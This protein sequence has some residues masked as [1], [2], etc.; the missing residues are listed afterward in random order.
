MPDYVEDQYRSVETIFDPLTTPNTRLQGPLV[1]TIFDGPT[2]RIFY[3]AQW[4]GIAPGWFVF[5][6]N[7]EY[8]GRLVKMVARPDVPPR[9]YKHWNGQLSRGWWKKCDAQE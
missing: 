3:V 2:T 7:E 1:E 8:G 5:G 9:K 6:R 4:H